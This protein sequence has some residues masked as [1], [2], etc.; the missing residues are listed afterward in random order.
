MKL[1]KEIRDNLGGGI[2][3]PAGLII[4]P[5]PPGPPGPQGLPGPQGP[6]PPGPP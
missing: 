6:L 5:S 2:N 1:F 4:P 3:R